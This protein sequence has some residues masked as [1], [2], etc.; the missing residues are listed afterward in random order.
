MTIYQNT[1]L[2]P[3]TVRSKLDKFEHVQGARALYRG[4]GCVQ[5]GRAGVLCRGGW[6]WGPTREEGFLHRDVQGRVGNGHMGPPYHCGQNDKGTRLK[7][8]PSLDGW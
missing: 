2:G 6:G 3:C 4:G 5:R 8:L 7:T 1:A